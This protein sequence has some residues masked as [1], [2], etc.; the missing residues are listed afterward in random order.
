MGSLIKASCNHNEI[1]LFAI[2]LFLQQWLTTSACILVI[3][4]NNPHIEL[5]IST[6]SK[7]YQILTGKILAEGN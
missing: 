2:V 1:Y 3:Q 4:N 6:F 5:G 7:V